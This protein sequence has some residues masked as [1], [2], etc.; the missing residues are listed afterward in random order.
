MPDIAT[1]VRRRRTFAIISHPVRDETAEATQDRH[2]LS[3]FEIAGAGRQQEPPD[4]LAA[5]SRAA[6]DRDEGGAREDSG[7]ALDRARPPDLPEG[8]ENGRDRNR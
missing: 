7:S 8:P 6:R 4:L 1:E 5:F 3:A 2:L